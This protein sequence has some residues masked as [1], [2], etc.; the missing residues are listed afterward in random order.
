MGFESKNKKKNI[1]IAGG[2]QIYKNSGP[3]LIYPYL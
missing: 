2:G 3:K 1:W